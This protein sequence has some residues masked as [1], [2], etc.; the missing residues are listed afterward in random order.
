MAA[1][2]LLLRR[3]RPGEFAAQAKLGGL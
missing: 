1:K 3:D 2:S